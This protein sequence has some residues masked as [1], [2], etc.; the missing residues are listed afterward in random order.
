[1]S[2][3]TLHACSGTLTILTLYKACRKWKVVVIDR[4]PM[5]WHAGK[6][7]LNIHMK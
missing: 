3:V 6:Q 7:L 5:S 2:T 1:M 4:C